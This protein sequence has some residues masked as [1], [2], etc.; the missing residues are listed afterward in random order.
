VLPAL[1][2]TLRAH[3]GTLL[4]D[5]AP[6]LYY[7]LEEYEP[8]QLLTSIPD[9]SA[10]A[11]SRDIGQ[12][13]PAYILLSFAVGGGGCG[14]EDPAVRQTQAQ[15]LHNIDLRVLYRI[16]SDGGYRLIARIPYR[17]TSFQSD[18]MLWAREGPRR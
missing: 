17:T 15:C 8:W 9:S 5:Q 2:A 18:Y 11:L 14:N 12:R 6:P 13:R 10:W 3:P 16:I 7:Y 4:T 1:T